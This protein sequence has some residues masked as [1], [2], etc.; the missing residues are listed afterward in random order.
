MRN[1]SESSTVPGGLRS[2][3]T[4]AVGFK[5]KMLPIAYK[6]SIHLIFKILIGK[7]TLI[8][9]TTGKLIHKEEITSYLC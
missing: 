4:K 6:C 2:L 5:C 8:K 3:S 1:D 7:T 9:A